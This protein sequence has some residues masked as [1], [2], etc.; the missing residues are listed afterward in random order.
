MDNFEKIVST[1]LLNICGQNITI[2]GYSLMWTNLKIF[3]DYY[4]FTFLSNICVS[5]YSLLMLNNITSVSLDCFRLYRQEFGY[6]IC[7]QR[8]TDALIYIDS[9]NMW[10]Y[11]CTPYI[12]T[13]Y[14]IAFNIFDFFAQV[15]SLVCVRLRKWEVFFDFMDMNHNLK[16]CCKK[17]CKLDPLA[18]I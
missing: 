7:D 18:P 2:V 11:Q 9:A 3:I 12:Y 14:I 6:Y 8:C 1:L 17:I 5:L 10:G 15:Y 16:V 13:I 4:C